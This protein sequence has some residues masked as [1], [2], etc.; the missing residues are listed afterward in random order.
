V[1]VRVTLAAVLVVGV[2]LVSGALVLVALLGS[3]L[4]KQVCADARERASQLASTVAASGAASTSTEL[5]QLIDRSGRR[6]R[7]AFRSNLLD[8]QRISS[9]RPRRWNP[10]AR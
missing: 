1:R 9:S 2:A 8:L 10:A 6:V 4:T 3:V 7:G 5:V